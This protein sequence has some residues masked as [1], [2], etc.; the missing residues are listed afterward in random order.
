MD[1]CICMA[2]SLCCLPETIMTLLIG[3]IP[4]QNKNFK[5]KKRQKKDILTL[6]MQIYFK[7]Y[8]DKYVGHIVQLQ[9]DASTF[10]LDEM[11]QKHTHMTEISSAQTQA[12]AREGRS[13]VFLARREVIRSTSPT[14]EQK[15]KI[16]HLRTQSL[17]A[18]TI[19]RRKIPTLVYGF[20]GRGHR[21]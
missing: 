10:S 15:Y 3:Y 5:K 16:R 1:T 11:R 19:W 9:E 13:P 17:A 20:S 7:C 6:E 21:W 2:G 18:C 8:P 12:G 4:I 14:G